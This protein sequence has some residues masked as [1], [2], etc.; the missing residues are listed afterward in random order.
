MTQVLISVVMATHNQESFLQKAVESVLEQDLDRSRFEVIVINDGSS[1]GSAEILSRFGGAI[2]L[3][4]H[5]NRG[6][7][8]CCNEGLAVARG[9]YFARVDSDDLVD[10]TWLS[11]L[12]E[13]LESRAGACAA[14]PDRWEVTAEGR[15]YV[16]VD[17]RN[18]FSLEACGTLFRTAALIRAGGFRHFYWEE[19]DLYLRLR[20]AGDLV[21]VPRGLYLYRKHSEG[22]TADFDRR[23][24]GWRELLE[25]WGPAALLEAGYDA[26]LHRIVRESNP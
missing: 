10:P 18:V 14:A 25:E 19:Y 6:L 26:E 7:V 4:E 12:L 8:S 21:R 24:A 22:M 15:E 3:I 2:H 20:S 13:V 16:A 23:A 17:P 9:R 1:D 5:E 11:L